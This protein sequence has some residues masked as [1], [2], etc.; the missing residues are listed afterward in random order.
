MSDR[1]PDIMSQERTIAIKKAEKAGIIVGRD[2]ALIKAFKPSWI[3]QNFWDTM[4]DEE[5][6]TDQWKHKSDK[7]KA[8]KATLKDGMVAKHTCGSR[9][10][11]QTRRKMVRN[12]KFVIFRFTLVLLCLKFN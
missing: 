11:S 3:N 8:N 2:Y 5:W 12:N 6:N 4:I 7:G 9:K 10:M 1:Y